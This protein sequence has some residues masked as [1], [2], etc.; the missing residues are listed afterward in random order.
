MRSEKRSLQQARKSV[1]KHHTES[2]TLEKRKEE[3]ADQIWLEV[4]L[5][6]GRRRRSILLTFQ[7]Y[8]LDRL[9]VNLMESELKISSFL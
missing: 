8:S 9:Q 4:R 1:T 2:L 3:A 6:C 7:E 5:M